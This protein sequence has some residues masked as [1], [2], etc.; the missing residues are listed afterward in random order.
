MKS[1]DKKNQIAIT[2]KFNDVSK[3]LKEC[4]KKYTYVSEL[5][6]AFKSDKHRKTYLN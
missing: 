5:I 2:G 6:E 3:F 1:K 4:E